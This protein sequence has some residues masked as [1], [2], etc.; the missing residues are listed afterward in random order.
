MTHSYLNSLI[1][2]MDMKLAHK[3]VCNP[4]LQGYVIKVVKS[5]TSKERKLLNRYAGERFWFTSDK[6]EAEWDSDNYGK[7]Y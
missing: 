3:D 2:A 6:P 1:G 7:L 4:V 5:L